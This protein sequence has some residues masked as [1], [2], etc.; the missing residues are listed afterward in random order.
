[1]MV[2]FDAI[3]LTKKNEEK[4]KEAQA[5]ISYQRSTSTAL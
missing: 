5:K 3:W 1:M 4:E 2:K